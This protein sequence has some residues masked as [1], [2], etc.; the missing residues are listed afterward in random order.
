MA[1]GILS[2]Q[3]TADIDYEAIERDFDIFCI[4]DGS[5]DY[6]KSNILDLPAAEFKALS[7]QYTYGRN[8]FVLFKKGSV[9]EARF[10]EAFCE[11]FKDACVKKLDITDPDERKAH[12]FYDCLLIQ[13]LANSVKVPKNELFSYNNTTGRLY[14]LTPEWRRENSFYCIEVKFEWEHIIKLYV[15]SFRKKC[16]NENVTGLVFDPQ[17]GGL[18]KKLSGDKGLCEY[19]AKGIKNRKHTVD[20]LKF[21]SYQDFC[22]SKLGIL[23]RFLNDMNE[24]YGAYVKISLKET[25]DTFDHEMP[26]SA[27]PEEVYEQY[28]RLLGGSINI[29]DEVGT[30]LSQKLTQKIGD[31]LTAFY[32]ISVSVG[33]LRPDCCNIRVIHSPEYYSENDLPDEYIDGLSNGVAV[34][35]I[36]LEENKHLDLAP[37]KIKPSADIRKIVQE[38]IIKRDIIKS[39]IS[40]S[41]WAGLGLDEDVT[42]AERREIIDDS[43]ESKD[44]KNKRKEYIYSFMRISPDGSFELSKADTREFLNA[45]ELAAA[46]IYDELCRKYARYPEFPEG[47][48]ITGDDK[49]SLIVRTAR[50][51]MPNIEAFA[52]SLRRGELSEELL[53]DALSAFR[54]DF[55]EYAGY[56]DRVKESLSAIK[57]PDFAAVNKCLDFRHN[58]KAASALNRYIFKNFDVRIN[59]EI[60]SQDNDDEY[61]LSSLCNIKYWYE[62]TVSGAE[63]LVYYVGMKRKELHRSVHNAC[64]IRKV[65]C[66]N[67]S[68][69]P[70]KLFPMMTVEFVRNE[71][72]TVRPFPFK[73]LREYANTRE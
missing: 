73:Y 50:T 54:E 25:Q 20:F 44:K 72:F 13:L 62:Q 16:E 23:Y 70:E 55:P 48:I 53:S 26:R 35:H 12:S 39:R 19:I 41:D 36:M 58:K 22:H 2:N 67:T 17:T 46:D 10:R 38:L 14:Y 5:D 8:A 32:G 4:S 3:Y 33:E 1:N 52:K 30:A 28:G 51:T 61:R 60:K 65:I 29:S 64:V 69:A 31:E 9:S 24:E 68:P 6:I 21:G 43:E 37:G 66:E 18:R 7:V 56:A 15:R 42:F 27:K 57:K 49:Y 34:Q 11:R 59:P 47:L 40:L 71:Q 45:D 63:A